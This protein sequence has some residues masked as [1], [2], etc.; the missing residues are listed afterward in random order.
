MSILRAVGG[1]LLLVSMLD[2]RNHL[3]GL[4]LISSAA[5]AHCYA[6][7]PATPNSTGVDSC[8]NEQETQNN[9]K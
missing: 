4:C 1:K 6:A 3:T 7:A 9:D 5:A 8:A 2:P